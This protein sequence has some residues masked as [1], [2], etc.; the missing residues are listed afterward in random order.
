MHDLLDRF[1]DRTLLG[2]PWFE[3]WVG[4]RL[5]LDVYTTDDSWVVKAN[6]PG[7]KPEEI[8]IQIS[9]DVL[10]IR[11]ETKEERESNGDEGKYLLRE[12]RV[13]SFS[14]SLT[15]PGTVEADQA[16]AEFENGVLTLTL[17]KP[18]EV[19]PKRIT[20]KSK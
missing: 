9:G 4:G 15:L 7:F 14:R 8:D 11:G 2:E 18:E 10:T 20:V 12:R 16:K 3:G 13:S 17:P 1:F 5:P 6:V 19:K